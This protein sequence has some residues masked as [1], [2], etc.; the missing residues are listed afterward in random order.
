[1]NVSRF[2]TPFRI[3]AHNTKVVKALTAVLCLPCRVLVIALRFK[4]E[5]FFQAR[6]LHLVARFA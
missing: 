5:E 6:K 3:L 4:I 2:I 1:M